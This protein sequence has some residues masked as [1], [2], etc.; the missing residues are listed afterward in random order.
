MG[1]NSCPCVTVVCPTANKNGMIWN[2]GNPTK[3]GNPSKLQKKN[4][5][6]FFLNL[7]ILQKFGNPTKLQK[8]QK[9]LKNKFKKICQSYK[10]YKKHKKKKFK[11]ILQSH[12]NLAI[13]QKFG[14][15]TKLQKYTKKNLT[16]LQN[17]KKYKK[18]NPTK[19]CPTASKTNMI[20]KNCFPFKHRI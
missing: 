16:I 12:K 4:I 3:F 2:N 9:N 15:P 6:I 17:Y 19:I 20:W 13:L 5:Y 10:N 18:G 1:K 14:N 8:I 11:K 7:A